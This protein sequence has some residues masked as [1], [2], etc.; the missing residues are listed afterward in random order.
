MAEKPRIAL[1]MSGGVDSAVC[2]ML[3]MDAGYEVTGV[4]C[5]F[6][7]DAASQA[8]LADAQAVCAQLGIPH[9]A[10][11][12]KAAF[13][14]AV[15]E[16]FVRD[17]AQG[18]TPSPCVSCNAC[19]KMPSLIAAADDLGCESVATGHYARVVRHAE[20][21][22]FVVKTALDAAKDQSYMLAQ[23]SQ[24]Q[25][26]RLVLPLGGTT[27]PAVRIAAQEGGLSV[28]GK[29]ESQDACFI[30][31]DYVDFL[32]AHGLPDEPGPIVNRAGDVL[33][34]HKGLF[35][36]TLGQR[37]GIGVAAH[38]PYY[39][40]G[41][42]PATRE[43]VVGFKDEARITG[44]QVGA[45]RW[46]AFE[47]LDRPLECMVKLRYRSRPAPCRVTPSTNTTTPV[48]LPCSTN[49]NSGEGRSSTATARV[50]LLSPQATTAPGQFAVFYQGD[51]LL[52]S[53]IIQGL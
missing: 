35:R 9:I 30:E 48:A 45:L 34:T 46:M 25:L 36:Y 40:V 13:A 44:L 43:L 52:G 20:R 11:D 15:V 37:K 7:H 24:A 16:P 19:C 8:A 51:T 14:A 1:G 17:Y 2:A 23:L 42:R 22:R 21:G 53:G 10:R 29:A 18:L 31:G 5:Q 47:R 33:G 4:T 12:C 26:A 49:T 39:V 32:K 3:L 41:K 50:Q 28:A 38:E 6:L 27:K